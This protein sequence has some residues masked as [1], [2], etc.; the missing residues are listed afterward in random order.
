[1]R[2]AGSAPSWEKRF[3]FRRRRGRCGPRP[4]LQA[5]WTG[6]CCSHGGGD[7][8]PCG[9]GLI[10]CCSSS[11]NYRAFIRLILCKLFNASP[12]ACVEHCRN[13][14]AV[15]MYKR[16]FLPALL[17]GTLLVVF[18]PASAL[19]RDQRGD[20]RGYSGWRGYSGAQ[21]RS[22][23]RGYSGGGGY[24]GGR[25]YSGGQ[26]YSG[27][28][29]YSGGR[30]NSGGRDYYGGR[31][32]SG[33]R[34]YDRGRGWGGGDRYRGGRGFGF[35]YYAA[36]YAYGPSYYYQPD[37]C[38]PNGYYDRWGYWHPP[39]PGCYADPYGYQC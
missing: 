31:G 4:K 16:F 10:I 11:S 38:N 23:A 37:Y 14:R 2:R 18:S 12:S 19:A 28:R 35:G 7:G 33:A 29:A 20:G 15:I 9:P 13:G 39:A 36:P 1:M 3:R 5:G 8:T 17:A 32:Y 27:G 34:N 24:S 22:G 25:G 6:H 21:G 26:G 30:G